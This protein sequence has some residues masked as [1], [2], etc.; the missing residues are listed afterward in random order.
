MDRAACQNRWVRPVIAGLMVLNIA[1]VSCASDMTVRIAPTAA[2]RADAFSWSE[3]DDGRWESVLDWNTLLILQAGLELEALLEDDEGTGFTFAGMFSV[4]SI[5]SG[6]SSDRDYSY[7]DLTI[8]SFS[9][10]EGE[11]SDWRAEVGY[12][13]RI[14]EFAFNRTWYLDILVG[15][16]QHNMDLENRNLLQTLP[17]PDSRAGAVASYDSTWEGPYL[18][19]QV[20]L[21]VSGPLV[22]YGR[23]T[24]SKTDFSGVADW[25]LRTDFAHPVSFEQE[26]DGWGTSMRAGAG[27]RVSDSVTLTG[28]LL[29]DAMVAEDGRD[30]TY[31]SD[32]TFVDIDLYEVNWSSFGLQGALVYNF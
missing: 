20:M 3:G 30:R 25:K 10:T 1:A 26:A 2:L 14:D 19:G 23:L 16:S 22:F 9:D 13:F 24:I 7:G 5:L 6:E 17:D 21:D 32:G 29:L 18:G 8:E 11:V 4:G 27:Y 12:R 31:F 15:Y 28:T